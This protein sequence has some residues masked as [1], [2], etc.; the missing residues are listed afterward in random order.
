MMSRMKQRLLSLSL[1]VVLPLMLFCTTPLA[2][3]ADDDAPKPD[4]KLANYPPN[5]NLGDGSVALTWILFI[6]L[7]V[8]AIGTMTKDAKRSHLD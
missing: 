6:F 5:A 1:A 7:T 2:L 3:A 8:I 4:A